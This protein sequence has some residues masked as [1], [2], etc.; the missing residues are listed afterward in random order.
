[1]IRPFNLFTFLSVNFYSAELLFNARNFLT[2]HDIYDD[3]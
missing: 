2:S 3:I 1:M